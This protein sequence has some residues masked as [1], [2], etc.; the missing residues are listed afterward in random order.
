[1]SNQP[2]QAA[3]A[4]W[5]RVARRLSAAALLT[6]ASGAGGCGW[7]GGAEIVEGAV[8]PEVEQ[9]PT[10]NVQVIR[11]GTRVRMTNTSS[12]AFGPSRLWANRWYSYP[13]ERGWGV[14]E[15]LEL[16]LEQFRDRYGQS[17]R[18]GGFFATETGESL[19][20]MQIQEGDE[21]IGLVVIG[22]PR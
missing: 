2:R 15:T 21:V 13:L 6:C 7:L 12:R 20:Q 17:F 22:R 18:A 9:G 11:D 1:M 19:V 16:S 4:R 14:G 10:L 8:Y 5:G 3:W